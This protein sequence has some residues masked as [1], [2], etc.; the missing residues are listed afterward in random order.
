MSCPEAALGCLMLPATLPKD[1]FKSADGGGCG[2]Y[3]RG[4]SRG[5]EPDLVL[6]TSLFEGYLD[7]A[8]TSIGLLSD[9]RVP[10]AVVHYDLI[11]AVREGYINSTEYAEFYQRKLASL[12]QADLLLAIS[13]HSRSEVVGFLDLPADRVINISAAVDERFREGRAT[14]INRES[15]LE[16]LGIK[17]QYVL[18]IPGGFDPRKNVC[19][20]FEAYAKLPPALREEYQLVI[21]SKASVQAASECQAAAESAG[22]A[23]KEWVLTGYVESSRLVDLYRG[24]TLFVFPSVHEDLSSIAGGNDFRRTLH[25]FFH[26]KRG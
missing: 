20:L 26:N 1:G 4:F 14:E 15:D 12:K 8:V 23:A 18:Y 9:V 17:S 5:S 21:G 3:Q 25:C 13:E 10:T 11:P 2:D 22:L 24:S 6:I 16:D 7:D 19:T